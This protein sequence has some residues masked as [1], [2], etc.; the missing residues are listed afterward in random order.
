[1]DEQFIAG[2]QRTITEN[3]SLYRMQHRPPTVV[4]VRVNRRVKA[5]ELVTAADIIEPFWRKT[6]RHLCKLIRRH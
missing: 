6:W 2:G 3:S 5:G 4:R 1:M